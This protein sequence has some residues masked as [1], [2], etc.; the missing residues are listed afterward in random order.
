MRASGPPFPLAA[1]L[2]AQVNTERYRETMRKEEK[3]VSFMYTCTL[4]EVKAGALA[5]W[6]EARLES[7]VGSACLLDLAS[8]LPA[9]TGLR[10]AATQARSTRAMMSVN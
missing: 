4:C 3:M 9:W 10:K 1:A 5:K 2:H 7:E 6:K 8:H